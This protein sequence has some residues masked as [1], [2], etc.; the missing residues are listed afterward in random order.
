MMNQEQQMNPVAVRHTRLDHFPFHHRCL[1][2]HHHRSYVPVGQ[3]GEE[4]WM[5]IRSGVRREQVTLTHLSSSNVPLDVSL[6]PSDETILGRCSWLCNGCS[7]GADEALV[8]WQLILLLFC[9]LWWWL[10]AIGSAG[11]AAVRHDGHRGYSSSN[12][13]TIREASVPPTVIRLR[14][15]NRNLAQ[16]IVPEYTLASAY[17][18]R[19]VMHG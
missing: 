13:Q 3:R 19:D 4:K 15:P 12:S 16:A 2:Y 5:W 8:L 14:L 1:Q 17:S 18:A 6:I 7:S 11:G 9:I 10:V